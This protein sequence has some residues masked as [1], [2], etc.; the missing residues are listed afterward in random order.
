MLIAN[1][2]ILEPYLWKA[3][4]GSRGWDMLGLEVAAYK[5]STPPPMDYCVLC[6]SQGSILTLF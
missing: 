5:N 2:K 6:L 1:T 4:L 3:E